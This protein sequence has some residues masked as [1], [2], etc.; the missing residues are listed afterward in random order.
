MD[1]D[2]L[3]NLVST[4]PGVSV[5]VT[6]IPVNCSLFFTSRSVFY[7]PY[8]WARPNELERTENNF[9]VF[10]FRNEGHPDHQCFDIL[11]KHFDF[12]R[13]NSVSL[14]DFLDAEPSFEKRTEDFA[15]KVELRIEAAEKRR[16]TLLSMQHEPTVISRN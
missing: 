9:W 11:T 2:F 7:D 10:E 12:V 3:R 15:R 1:K 16:L 14:S 5:H 13:D 4:Y 6:D 8:L